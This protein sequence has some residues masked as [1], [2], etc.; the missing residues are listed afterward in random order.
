MHI[1]AQIVGLA[2]VWMR[3]KLPGWVRMC[4]L[5]QIQLPAGRGESRTPGRLSTPVG[6]RPDG[7]ARRKPR[8]WRM[9][10]GFSK[11]AGKLL[12]AADLQVDRKSTRLNSS[13]I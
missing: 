11:T 4:R 1:T 13:H 2:V 9:K 5:A 6:R 10:V 12:M 3:R 8:S 7:V